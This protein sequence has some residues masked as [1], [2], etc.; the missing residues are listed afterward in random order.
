MTLLNRFTALGSFLFLAA[1]MACS[2]SGGG[3]GNAAAAGTA[4]GGS[5]GVVGN[6]AGSGGTSGAATGASGSGGSNVSGGGASGGSGG[7]PAAGSAGESAGGA[8]GTG[9]ASGTL[10]E[11]PFSCTQYIGAYLSQEWYLGG[12]FEDKLEAN[13]GDGDTWQLKWHHHGYVT[14][15]AD[16]ESPFWADEGDPNNDESGSPIVSACAQNSTAPDRIIMLVIDWEMLDETLWVDALED[17]VATLQLK[18]PSAQRIDLM[19]MIRCPDN[20]MC[21]GGADYGEGA[22]LVAG[23]QDCYVQPYVDSAIAKVAA[24][25]PS[26]VGIGP[27]TEAMMCAPNIDGAHLGGENNDQAASDIAEFY[28]P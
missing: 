28:A 6:T 21:N 18:Y 9:G 27:K 4:A 14:W 15:W 11:G 25:H 8:G 7:T 3:D 2:D 23:R 22:N 1:G 16:P 20:T 5:A 26:L 17:L 24:A 13:G 12:D 10:S 19:T